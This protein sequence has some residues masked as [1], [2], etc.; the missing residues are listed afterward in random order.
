MKELLIILDG[1]SESS[2]PEIRPPLWAAKTNIIQKIKSEGKCSKKKFYPEGYAPDSLNCILTIL[3]VPKEYIP[4]GRAWLEAKSIGLDIK[5]EQIVMRCNLV[6]VEENKLISFNGGNLNNEE[7]Y[8][9][10]QKVKITENMD[11]YHLSNYRNL[12]LLDKES[13]TFDGYPPH[14]HIGESMDKLL[15]PLLMSKELHNFI[16]VNKFIKG[17]VEYMYYPWGKSAYSYIPSFESLHNKSSILIAEAEIVK[18]IGKAMNMVLVELENSTGDVDTD[19]NEKYKYICKGLK[20]KDVIVCHINGTDEV[21]HR[22]D[23]KGKIKFIERIDKELLTPIYKK[24]EK[25]NVKLTILSDHRTS[26]LTGKHEE[27]WVDV[28]SI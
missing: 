17:N 5:K 12:L 15:E 18:G 22:K 1:V 16:C 6:A 28:L 7:Q 11:F 13:V 2:S 19:L 21:S 26:S 14:E 4:S 24:I 23:Y 9:L 10:S 25:E 8:S 3:G 20:E 27:G